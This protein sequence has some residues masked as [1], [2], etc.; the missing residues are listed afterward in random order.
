MHACGKFGMLAF[1]KFD[2]LHS[3]PHLENSVG[4]FY[5]LIFVAKSKIVIPI[6][7]RHMRAATERSGTRSLLSI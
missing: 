5:V 6:L 3:E 7:L 4:R 2:T 1:L